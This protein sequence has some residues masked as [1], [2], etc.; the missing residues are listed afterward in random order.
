MRK[1]I[2]IFAVLGGLVVYLA[3]QTLG[4]EPPMT[5]E[6]ILAERDKAVATAEEKSQ[7]RYSNAARLRTL[8]VVQPDELSTERILLDR[9]AEI[10]QAMT[11]ADER[12][13]RLRAQSGGK[14]P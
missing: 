4:E 8:N 1:Y 3:Y 7:R 2:W 5:I 11:R 13:G 9:Q 14:T 6:Q 12:M 10:L